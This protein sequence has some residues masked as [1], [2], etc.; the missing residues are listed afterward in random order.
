MLEEMPPF[1]ERESSILAKLKRKKGPGAG[2]ALDDGRRDPSSHDINGGVEPT[3][4]TVVSP[5]GLGHQGG[6]QLGLQAVLSSQLPLPS[7][8]STPSP[9]A[10]LLGLRAAPP[11]AAPPAPSGAGQLLVDVFSDGPAGQPSLGPTPEEAFLRY[12]PPRAQGCPLSICPLP[13]S[14]SLLA[15]SLCPVRPGCRFPRPPPSLWAALASWLTLATLCRPFL[16][17]RLSL[18]FLFS[19]PP[20]SLSIS[21]FLCPLAASL[22]LAARHACLLLSALGLDGPAS[23]SRLPLRA[24]WLCWL[25]QL[26]LLSKGWPQGVGGQTL[27]SPGR[28]RGPGALVTGF[29][30]PCG[31]KD[32][33]GSDNRGPLVQG[34]GGDGTCQGPVPIAS[35]TLGL[36]GESGH[37]DSGIL[38]LQDLLLSHH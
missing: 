33:E 8:Q 10:D 31:G 38:S 3:P 23:W 27:V 7:S 36:L 18:L 16:S 4:S 1:P 9:S 6:A 34:V 14:P 11:P 24:P 21:L 28:V 2:S 29:L 22:G 26:Q 20:P 30:M 37:M 25:T 32:L 12:Q 15:L 35:L 13:T 17:S 5:M 19:S